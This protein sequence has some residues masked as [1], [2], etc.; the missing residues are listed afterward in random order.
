[1]TPPVSSDL[2]PPPARLTVP[3]QT[4][5]MD[6]P[7]DWDVYL[8]VQRDRHHQSFVTRQ[9]ATHPFR[10]SNTFYLDHPH[11]DRAY[12][13]LMNTSPGLMAQ[14]VFHIGIDLQTGARLYLTDQAATKVHRMAPPHQA[15]VSYHI[16]LGAQSSLE[17][18]PDPLILYADAHL[19][20]QTQ[21]YL[22]PT[23]QLCLSEII[24]PGR[25]ARQEYYQFHQY[26]SRLTLHAPDGKLI[27][28]DAL[29]LPGRSHPVYPSPLFS[30]LPIMGS[31]F[32]IDP[33]LDCPALMAALD[34]AWAFPGDP[35]SRFPALALGQS[36]TLEV[37]YSP[38]P[39]CNGLLLRATADCIS[40]IKTC[41]YHVVSLARDLGGHPPLPEVPK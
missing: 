27:L 31:L 39:N 5:S 20:Q 35:P 15:Q 10:L 19:T 28:G 14:D 9:Y 12:V 6:T 40:R 41:F 22:H 30:R 34:R 29:Q 21:V 17:F 7:R 38:L 3:G 11:R 32:L 13:Y 8:Q 18:L 37:G 24:V 25:L 16:H 4:R 1:M 23:A 2:L 33:T 36:D 26:T